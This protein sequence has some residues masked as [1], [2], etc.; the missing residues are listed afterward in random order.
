MP[1]KPNGSFRTLSKLVG[2]VLWILTP[3]LGNWPNGVYL[4]GS[5][6]VDNGLQTQNTRKTGRLWRDN[7]G[8]AQVKEEET[9]LKE[10]R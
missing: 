2:D 7:H 10:W 4:N 5:E 6:L 3:T 8:Y 9:L 1:A